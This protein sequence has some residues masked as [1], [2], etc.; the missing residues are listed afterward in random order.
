[1]PVYGLKVPYLILVQAL[2]LALFVIDF[3]GPAVATDARDPDCLPVQTVRIVINGRIGKIGLAK[4]DD[5]TLLAEVVYAMSVAI[6]VVGLLFAL[7]WDS[8]LSEKWFTARCDGLEVLSFETFG[9]CLDRYAPAF[10]NDFIVTGQGA[11]VRQLQFLVQKTAEG[12]LGV[13]IVEG[14]RQ[15]QLG[16]FVRPLVY[17]LS[18]NR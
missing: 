16:V 10:Q 14:D 15:F 13:P 17:E 4:A 6:A 2:R 12:R 9:E 8:D 1:M 5:Q 7:V 3:D 11:N 18:S